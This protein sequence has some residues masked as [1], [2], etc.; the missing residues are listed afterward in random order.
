MLEAGSRRADLVE[1][2]EDDL[3]ELPPESELP[4][5][6]SL[7]PSSSE[8]ESDPESSLLR[9]DADATGLPLPP[10]NPLPGVR[11]EGCTGVDA[12]LPP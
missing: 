6:L 10:P 9:H 3:D 8:L 4:S 11:E 1:E 7:A 12:P 5:S 2:A